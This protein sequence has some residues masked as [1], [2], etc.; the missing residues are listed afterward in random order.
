MVAGG[1][2][3]RQNGRKSKG[4][5]TKR[6]KAIA[7]KNATKHGLLAKKPPLLVTEDY[8]TFQGLLNGLISEWQPEGAT[9]HF[10]V[11]SLAMAMLRQ[12]RLWGYEAASINHRM[13]KF[14]YEQKY[15][16]HVTKPEESPLLA[17]L[18]EQ[19]TPYL[20][21]LQKEKDILNQLLDYVRDDLA[22]LPDQSGFVDWLNSVAESLGCSY[23]HGDRSAQVY[24]EQDRLIKWLYDLLDQ[25]DGGTYPGVDDLVLELRKVMALAKEQLTRVEDKLVNL[26]KMQAEIDEHLFMTRSLHHDPDKLM[27]YQ[28]SISKEVKGILEQLRNIRVDRASDP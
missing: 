10:L 28:G 21:M 16:E 23:F 20:E 9:E 15:P 6:G 3:S 12:Y 26:D 8:S 7:S 4:A 13:L 11:Q 25:E 22:E 1:E 19:R 27:R 5:K 17:N 2:I 14:Q 18:I 24:K